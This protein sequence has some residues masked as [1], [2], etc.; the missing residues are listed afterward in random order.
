M[1]DLEICHRKSRCST[2]NS[3]P[4]SCAAGS[5]HSKRINGSHKPCQSR[6][7]VVRADC[8]YL[9]VVL[10]QG[11]GNSRGWISLAVMHTTILSPFIL[12]WHFILDSSD[13]H[14]LNIWYL[15]EEIHWWP[16]S[17]YAS[18]NSSH[19]YL[20][21]AGYL[22]GKKCAQCILYYHSSQSSI[23]EETW[24]CPALY[25]SRRM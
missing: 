2:A 12:A 15:S 18:L 10:E 9:G 1:S 6:W 19:S 5:Q 20:Q 24:L 14:Q 21:H 3:L 11:M 13:L 7:N 23:G 16:G 17:L 22:W 4:L 25:W 8:G